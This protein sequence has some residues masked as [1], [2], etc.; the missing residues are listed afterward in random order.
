MTNRD[1]LRLTFAVG[2]LLSAT[3]LRAQQPQ[4][5]ASVDVVRLSV[6]VVHEGGGVVPPLTIEDFTVFDNGVPQEIRL[7]HRPEDTP[8]RVAL[9]VDASPSLRPWWTVVQRAAIS[10]VA[11]MG[12]RGCPYLLPFSDGIGPGQWGR[13]PANTWRRFFADV[14]HGDGTSLHDAVLIALNELARVD[15]LAIAASQRMRNPGASSEQPQAPGEGEAVDPRSLTREELL[16]AFAT[17]VARIIAENPYTHAGN[18]DLRYAPAAPADPDAG[19]PTLPE[20]ES[21]KAVLL[22]SDGAD[23]DS[24]ASRA[25]VI[26]AARI[27]NVPIFPVLL[28]TAAHDRE[29]GSLLE[30]LARATGGLV[31]ENVALDELG[32]AYDRVLGLLRSTYVLM[33]EPRDEPVAD[34]AAAAGGGDPV[35]GGWRELRVELRRPLLTTIVRE[36]Y[37]R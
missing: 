23:T 20:D 21:V 28:G 34:E 22:L 26:N 37:Y 4:I 32:T 9:L 19:S 13:F 15:E 16:D 6:A 11:K 33:Y 31:I 18:C 17:M 3:P 35:A 27:A 2:A 30:E 24:L 14:R 8:L 1:K 10:F 5:S 29:L 36:G 12:A 25:D 7:L